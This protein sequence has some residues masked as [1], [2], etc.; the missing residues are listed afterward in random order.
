MRAE[1]TVIGQDPT[2]VDHATLL[3]ILGV[4][5][6]VAVEQG[7]YVKVIPDANARQVPV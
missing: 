2:S 6:F 1:V 3:T 7:G 5:G 4:H